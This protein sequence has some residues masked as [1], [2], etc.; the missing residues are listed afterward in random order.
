MLC[1]APDNFGTVVPGAVYRSSYPKAENYL[2]LKNLGL[3][4]ILYA[5]GLSRLLAVPD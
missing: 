2:Y 4:T 5:L 3:K 1:Y